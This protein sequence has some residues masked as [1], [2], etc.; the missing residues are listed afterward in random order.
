M[1]NREAKAKQQ[2]LTIS[3]RFTSEKL[4]RRV[5]KR[6][7]SIQIIDENR[8]KKTRKKL[9]ESDKRIVSISLKD[10]FIQNVKDSGS[11][12][13]KKE[14]AFP[15]YKKNFT[16]GIYSK[17]LLEHPNIYLNSQEKGALPSNMKL[18]HIGDKPRRVE[19]FVREKAA[20]RK[21][22]H[23]KL[24]QMTDNYEHIFSSKKKMILHRQ[25]KKLFQNLRMNRVQHEL[26]GPKHVKHSDSKHFI[27]K[28]KENELRPYSAPID[29]DN[30]IFF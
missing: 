2:I 8:V 19:V 30:S 25:R 9:I 10:N 16:Q 17:Y 15:H 22:E 12:K 27:G 11:Y 29:G 13:K 21:E 6:A 7:N 14:K 5:H 18:S 1:K 26:P 23:A 4:N 28:N 20:T 24:Q 3:N